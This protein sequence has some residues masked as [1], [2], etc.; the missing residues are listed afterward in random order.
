MTKKEMV[1]RLAGELGIDQTLTRKIVQK[2]LDSIIDALMTEGRIELRN[3]GVF[4]VRTRAAR[5]ARN[6]KTNQQVIV[7]PRRVV[8]FQP[9]KNVAVMVNRSGAE[10]PSSGGASE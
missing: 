8:V 3:F 6:P 5:T 7:P 4:E 1:R 2:T 9:G 10:M